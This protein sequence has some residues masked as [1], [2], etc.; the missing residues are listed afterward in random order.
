MYYVT[1]G[2]DYLHD[3][4][5]ELLLTSTKL[6]VE[7][8]AAG[9]FAF[10]L[11]SEHPLYGKIKERDTANPVKVYQDETLIFCGDILAIEDGFDLDKIVTC[12]GELAWLNDT[13][14]RPYSTLAEECDN[15]AP[16]TVDG[17][18]EWLIE[19]HNSQVEPTKQF[20]IGKNE[21][22]SL[23]ANNYLYRSDS[24]YPNTGSVIKEKILDSLGGYVQVRHEDG[25]RYIDLLAD[26]PK[27]NAQIIDF[28]VNLLDYDKTDTTDDMATF[29]IPVGKELE[30]EEESTDT[31]V[32]KVKLRLTLESLGDGYVSGDYFK[33]RDVLYSD[34]AVKK[35]GWIGAVVQFDDIT[36]V[37]NLL[38]SGI[39]AL[40]GLMTP[41]RTVE[42]TAIDLAMIK[43]EYEPI[44]IGQ[45]VRARSAPHDFDSYM[46]C[47]SMTV[48][49][50]KPDNNKFVLGTTFDLLTGVQNKRIKALNATIN[51][52]YQVANAMSA[53]AKAAAVVATEASSNAM[54]AGNLVT[55]YMEYTEDGGL[56][57]G[58]KSSG[59][60][61]GYRSQLTDSSFN[62]IDKA[63][64]I[65]SSFE[66]NEDEDYLEV[67]GDYL[68]LRAEHIASLYA[69]FHDGGQVG[70][71]STIN[72]SSDKIDIWSQRSENLEPDGVGTWN[73]TNLQI[74]P[75]LIYALT[76]TLTLMARYG[77]ELGTVSG[78]VTVNGGK[79]YGE[80]VL[81]DNES[82]SNGTITLSQSA[83]SFTYLEIFYKDNN[84]REHQSMKIYSPN[85]K[86]S[87]LH[88]IEAVSASTLIR[89]TRY[90]ISGTSITPDSSLMGYL[91]IYNEGTTPKSV[92]GTNFIYITRV[93][94][95]V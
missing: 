46:L 39:L 25:C 13:L 15:V 14:V 33:L 79:V 40:K 84:D 77:L 24:T 69:Y 30:E 78:D 36:E 31:D 32:Q 72:V 10:T 75:Y 94:G 47:S 43:P 4:R 55:N 49:I 54:E 7:V 21:G 56:Q 68:R 71:K 20:K 16:S 11:Y 57:T 93:V 48:D 62:I 88:A 81:Y 51:T 26:F 65:V 95:Y 85:G 91:Q 18:F 34:S 6:E 86:T 70:S 92:T 42:V 19:N 27:V 73:S 8:N 60:W 41:V 37:E 45:Y 87:D 82:G 52:V 89:R 35:Y 61:V 29:I 67:K 38:N 12:R 90:S 1:Y 74:T 44:F 23:D 28:G 53:T 22:S 76:D 80:T 17:Y 63:G 83:A 59:E 2:H 58:N 66:Y 5:A 50:N 3:P 9:S 64:D